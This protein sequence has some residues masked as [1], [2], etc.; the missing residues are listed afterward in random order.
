MDHRFDVMEILDVDD[1]DSII[2]QV[3]AKN[4]SLT[5]G[6]SLL[7]RLCQKNE[8]LKED[9]SLLDR[10]CQKNESLTDIAITPAS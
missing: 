7:D 5:S 6:E 4:E 2:Q 8:S 10:L 3:C 1:D 9:T